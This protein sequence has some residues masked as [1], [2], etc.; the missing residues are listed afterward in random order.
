MHYFNQLVIFTLAILPFCSSF[1]STL[2]TGWLR[3]NTWFS[4]S[5]LA[6]STFW[7]NAW[8]HSKLCDSSPWSWN[9]QKLHRNLQCDTGYFVK[10][11][12]IL[13]IQLFYCSSNCWN[14]TFQW[15][16]FYT[17]SRSRLVQFLKVSQA[18]VAIT[19]TMVW[20][21]RFILFLLMLWIAHTDMMHLIFFFGSPCISSHQHHWTYH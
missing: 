2:T 9:W 17:A 10:S 21:I 8:C 18:H 15:I 12:P 3:Y 4:Q 11:P 7:G 1:S 16:H 14:W 6:G 5:Q 13:H 19:T 20:D